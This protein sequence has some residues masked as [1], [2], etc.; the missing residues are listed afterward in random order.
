MTELK[1]NPMGVYR[2]DIPYRSVGHSWA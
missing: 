2:A 1:V